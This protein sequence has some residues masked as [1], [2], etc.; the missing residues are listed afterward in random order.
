M[1]AAHVYKRAWV[2]YCFQS[3]SYPN[4]SDDADS[5]G[6]QLHGHK[7]RP[8]SDVTNSGR[9]WRTVPESNAQRLR[10]WCRLTQ[11]PAFGFMKELSGGGGEGGEAGVERITAVSA[12]ASNYETPPPPSRLIGSQLPGHGGRLHR[13]AL[14][15]HKILK[16]RLNL[17]QEGLAKFLVAFFRQVEVVIHVLSADV[18]RG[19]FIENS[20]VDSHKG[21]V[22]SV[23]QPFL[24]RSV[25]ACKL[26]ADGV[27]LLSSWWQT[28]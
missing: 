16:Q 4:L 9:V 7:E 28:L 27:G 13:R 21:G 11:N 25:D 22:W 6:G 18:L 19:G 15:L 24:H 14:H 26:F 1:D 2:L 17:L 23:G 10:V 12:P 20:R 3:C 8:Y 5:V